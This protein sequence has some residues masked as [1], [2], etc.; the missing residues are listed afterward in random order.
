[1]SADLAATV[2]QVK[3]GDEVTATFHDD[4]ANT[5]AVSGAIW[6]SQS[7]ALLVGRNIVRFPSVRQHSW[8]TDLVINTPAPYPE[9]P[10]GSV[11]LDDQG[12]AWQSY[13]FGRE[14][15]WRSVGDDSVLSWERFT[16][17]FGPVRVVY[18]P[19]VTP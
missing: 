11:V 8:L 18:T 4:Y 16:D 6:K 3:P 14:A 17:I 9:P 5:Y 7:G 2:A 19:E 12:D 1:M 15:V 13:R 10:I